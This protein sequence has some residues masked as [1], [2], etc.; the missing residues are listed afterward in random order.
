MNAGKQK[1]V[2]FGLGCFGRDLLKSFVDSWHVAAVDTDESRI[3]K[4]KAEAPGAEYHTGPATSRL[5]WKK[6]DLENIKTIICSI[7]DTGV[8]L[9]ICRIAREA[10]DFKGELFALIYNDVDE[11]AYEPY[12]V[13]LVNPLKPGLRSILNILDKNVNHAVN[14]GIGAGEL[15]EVQ[16]NARSH[17]VGR[18]LKHIKPTLWHISAVYRKG[19]LIMPGGN[20]TL[21]IGDRVVLVGDPKVL[22][23]VTTILLK[24]H[25]Q[26]PLQYGSDIVFPLQTDFSANMDEAIYW[27]NSF[28]S[29]RM[30]FIP[31]RKKL[32]GEFKDKIKKEASP[33]EVGTPID[34]FKE[35]FMQDLNTGVLVVPADRGW[36]RYRHIHET[37][38]KSTKPF[39]LSRL[40]YEYMGVIISFNGPD[41]VQA[42]ETGMQIAN[43][44]NIPFRAVYVTFPKEMRG[45]EEDQKLRLRRQVI[46]DFEGI[47]QRTIEYTVLEGNPVRE[48]LKHLE[49]VQHHL[50]VTTTRTAAPLRFLHPNAPYLIAKKTHLSTLVIPEADTDE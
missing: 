41:P 14:I 40:A 34:L 39:L 13:T 28:K 45:R 46:S 4:S 11:K 38:K 37:F 21:K 12:N 43:L 33:F 32:S 24:G 7:R 2:L 35:I 23:N 49:T 10:F 15:I 20:C 18:K 17:L 30:Q 48:T 25:P 26:F 50:L 1:M 27:K 5:T 22:E 47:H 36:L 19:K 44:L 42:L 29:Q 3:E 9:E 6:L 16:I 8:S 31:F